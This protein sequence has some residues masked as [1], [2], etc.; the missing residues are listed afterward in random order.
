MIQDF[1]LTVKDSLLCPKVFFQKIS[2]EKEILKPILYLFLVYLSIAMFY[3][4]SSL[5]VALSVNHNAIVSGRVIDPIIHILLLPISLTLGTILAAFI[6]HAWC[7][8]FGISKGG[9]IGTLRVFCYSS[10]PHILPIIGLFAAP[11]WQLINIT[12]GLKIIHKTSYKKLLI[13]YVTSILL[14]TIIAVI[15]T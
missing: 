1:F 12:V 5:S 6:F 13:A 2:N 4:L 15:S 10:T 9:L 14:T 3:V 11:I 8:F 7:Y